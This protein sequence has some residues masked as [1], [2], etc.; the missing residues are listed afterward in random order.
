M[1]YKLLNITDPANK[2]DVTSSFGL[3]F[4]RSKVALNEWIAEMI[5]SSG[6]DWRVEYRVKF[7]NTS[8]VYEWVKLNGDTVK[9]S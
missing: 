1:R 4:L 5:L 8:D 7:K 2:V 6:L 3:P 9:V